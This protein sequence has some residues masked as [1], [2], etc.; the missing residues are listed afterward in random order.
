MS[1]KL[2]YY[3]FSILTSDGSNLSNVI[4]YQGLFLGQILNQDSAQSQKR[5]KPFALIKYSDDGRL[6]T[7]WR[8]EITNFDPG[9]NL[10][11]FPHPESPGDYLVFTHPESN[12]A[13]SHCYWL[14]QVGTSTEIKAAQTKLVGLK[15]IHYHAGKFI[16]VFHTNIKTRKHVESFHGVNICEIIISF[17]GA[18]KQLIQKGNQ[19]DINII[20]LKL[21][22]LNANLAF[23]N[24]FCSYISPEDDC[25]VFQINLSVQIKFNILTHETTE[26]VKTIIFL[27]ND[28]TLLKNW[29]EYGFPHDPLLNLRAYPITGTDDFSII[30]TWADENIYIYKNSDKRFH[31][32]FIPEQ[33]KLNRYHAIRFLTSNLAIITNFI[34]QNGEY[35]QILTVLDTEKLRLTI[36]SDKMFGN[37]Q[38]IGAIPNDGIFIQD[39]MYEPIRQPKR[40]PDQPATLAEQ[41]IARVANAMSNSTTTTSL[42]Y[43]I[44]ELIGKFTLLRSSHVRAVATLDD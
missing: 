24:R 42:P 2:N 11:I 23:S 6:Q 3:K 1:A 17:R 5:T 39:S 4:E 25:L 43:Q 10:E 40:R 22:Y 13:S 38:S 44:G 41:T 32:V 20:D 37:C 9:Y 12:L 8:G 19:I 27:Q 36:I 21:S 30:D 14:Q 33:L 16:G 28:N 29:D 31:L 15:Y 7:L 34:T 18:K 35:N 26:S